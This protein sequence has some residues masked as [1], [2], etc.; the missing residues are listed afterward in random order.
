MYIYIYIY[1]YIYPVA[2]H[3][4][5]SNVNTPVSNV[6]KPSVYQAL[7]PGDSSRAVMQYS[8][9]GAGPSYGYHKPPAGRALRVAD[10]T[11]INVYW[12]TADG[13]TAFRRYVYMYVCIYIYIYICVCVCKYINIYLHL[14]IYIY[15]YIYIRALCV[16]DNTSINDYWETADGGT[17]FRRYVSLSLSLSLYIYIY[18]YVYIYIYI[19]IY[20]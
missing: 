18:I 17:A 9:S 5:A 10:N 12:E 16:A 11:S 19:Y 14:Y 3:T 6:N 20:L 2:H 4:R 15:I 8:E 13:G 7:L 1:I